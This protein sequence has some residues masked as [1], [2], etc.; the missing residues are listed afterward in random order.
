MCISATGTLKANGNEVAVLDHDAH[1]D[2]RLLPALAVAVDVPAAAHQHVRG[3]R[4]AAGEVNQQPFAARF[5]TFYDLAG[6]RRVVVEAREQRVSGAED[7]DRLAGERAAQGARG[8]KDG[9]AFRHCLTAPRRRSDCARLVRV[10][11]YR[12]AECGAGAC[13]AGRDGSRRP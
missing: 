9:I 1:V 10:M 5:D 2:A 13:R 4:C 11:P 12:Q 7:R 3:Q 8:A 6:D